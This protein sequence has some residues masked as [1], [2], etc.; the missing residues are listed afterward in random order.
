MLAA[1]SLL[2]RGDAVAAQRALE[3]YARD[4]ARATALLA[5]QIANGLPAGERAARQRSAEELQT[6]TAL[7]PRDAAAWQLLGHTWNGLGQPLRALRAEAEA[8]GAVADTVGAIDRLRAGRSL[9]R[10]AGTVDHIEAAV[11]DARLRDL[12]AQRRAEM[13]E[14]RGR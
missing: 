7:N 13:A 3:P 4:G 9:A 14:E 12:E 8:R 1:Q 10:S 6:W 2:A 5:A 11:I